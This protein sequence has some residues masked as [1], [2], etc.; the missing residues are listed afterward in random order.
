MHHATYAYL[1][2]NHSHDRPTSISLSS[3]AAVYPSTWLSGSQPRRDVGRHIAAAA[4]SSPVS[5][6]LAATPATGNQ[7]GRLEK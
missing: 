7:D 1:S 6:S 3:L 2:I 4:A 5:G